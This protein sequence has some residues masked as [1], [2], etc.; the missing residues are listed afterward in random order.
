MQY[1]LKLLETG[2]NHNLFKLKQ[3]AKWLTVKNIGT[4]TI[5]CICIAIENHQQEKTTLT[6]I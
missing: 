2:L 1:I 4:F 3:A 5:S 6:K